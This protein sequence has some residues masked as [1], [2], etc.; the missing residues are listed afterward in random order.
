LPSELDAEAEEDIET[1]II[2]MNVESKV[3]SAKNRHKG[4]TLG[5]KA[6]F[7]G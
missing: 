6:P 1:Q 7:G 2:C 5:Q 4:P 3:E